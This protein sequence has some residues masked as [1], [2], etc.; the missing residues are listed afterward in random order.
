M[1]KIKQIFDQIMPYVSTGI[2]FTPQGRVA[3]IAYKK[4]KTIIILGIIG[5]CGVGLLVYYLIKQG[6][7][8]K[9]FEWF[10]GIGK[11]MESSYQKLGQQFTNSIKGIQ[12]ETT[13]FTKRFKDAFSK[14][15][16]DDLGSMYSDISTGGLIVNNKS[17]GRKKAEKEVKK[18][19]D[20]EIKKIRRVI[21]W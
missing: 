10:K 8:T 2:S 9:V 18:R 13:S 14:L 16:L 3:S 17:K 4:R 21:G 12:T 6:Y 11:Q 7:F 1:N 15:K 19:V 20:K 5:T